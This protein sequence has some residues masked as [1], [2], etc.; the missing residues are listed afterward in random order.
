MKKM[1]L[2]VCSAALLGLSGCSSITKPDYVWVMDYEQMRLVEAANRNS[3][4][5]NQMHWVNPPMKRIPRAEYERMQQ[6]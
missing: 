1:I 3:A 4:L 5:P 6:Q 2:S